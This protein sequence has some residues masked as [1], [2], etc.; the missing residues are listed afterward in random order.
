MYSKLINRL[1]QARILD[2]INSAVNIEME[3]V[4]DAL[5]G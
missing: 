3:V 2:I 1:S 4:V 5:P